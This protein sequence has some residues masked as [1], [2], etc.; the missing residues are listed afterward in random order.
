MSILRPASYVKLG[1]K[2]KVGYG[3]GDFASN[4]SFGFVSLFLLYFYT[5]IYGLTAAQASLIFV[6]ARVIDAGFNLIVGYF[7]DKTNTRHGKLRPYLLY[8]AIPLGL[9]TVICFTAIETEHKFWFAMVSYTLY[10]LAYTTVNTPYSA[11]TNMLTQ[12]EGSRASLSVYR[13]TFA[14]FGYLI[15]STS[16]ESIVS[17]FTEPKEGYVFAASCFALLATFLFLACFG[18]TK[19]RIELSGEQKNPS[20]LDLVQSVKR[21]TPLHILSVYTTF[22]YI[23][24]ILWMAVAVY[25]VNYVLADETFIASFF[26]IQTAAYCVG[27]VVTGKLVAMIGKKKLI[28]VSLPI[29]AA[30]LVGQY[31]VPAGNVTLI[32]ACISIYSIVLAIN[33]VAMWSMLAD[34]VEYTEW[35]TGV[36]AEGAIYGYFNFVTKIAMAIGGGLAGMLLQIYGYNPEAITPEAIDG[37]NIIMT[38]IPAVMF[39]FGFI[40]IRFYQIDEQHYLEMIHDIEQ[41]KSATLCENT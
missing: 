24:Y 15:V 16:A 26:V 20:L 32:M 29:G 11:M 31:F 41:R 34:T 30:A 10:C 23:T 25:Y 33:F 36:R 37:I 13:F 5:D 22:I 6:V 2:E 28:L 9:L 21:N 1:N 18:T 19:E 27:T 39:I 3:L 14:M 17:Q 8:G 40:F 35:Q 38:S 7:I 4:L 12:H